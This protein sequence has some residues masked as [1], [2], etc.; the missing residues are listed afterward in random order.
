MAI[1]SKLQ[2]VNVQNQLPVMK[3]YK[4]L[5]DFNYLN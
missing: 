3:V 2:Y 5:L 1:T 4:R